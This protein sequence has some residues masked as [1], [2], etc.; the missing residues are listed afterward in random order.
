MDGNDLNYYL[1]QIPAEFL[2]ILYKIIKNSK[3][4]TEFLKSYWP[5]PP[6]ADTMGYP[7][8]AF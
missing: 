8:S 6:G 7:Y 1:Y 5:I 2:A 4:L 3:V